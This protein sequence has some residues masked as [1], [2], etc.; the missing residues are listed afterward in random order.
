MLRETAGSAR[1][2]TIDYYWFP[3][4]PFTYLAGS[5]LEEVAARHGAEVVYRPVQLFR[6]F[7]E[8]GTPVVKD[9]HPSRQEYRLADI[10]RTAAA[11][12][13]PINLKPAFCRPTRR[14]RRS[15]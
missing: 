9:R 10:A 11:N 15:R 4:S 2:A 12:G 6:I 1:M 5:R 8:T 14:R 3:I 13:M 7:A